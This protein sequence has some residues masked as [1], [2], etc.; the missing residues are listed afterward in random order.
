MNEKSKEDTEYDKVK[1]KNEDGLNVSYD[2]NELDQF[3]PHLM[4]EIINKEK[5]IQI[6]SID[7]DVEESKQLEEKNVTCLDNLSN[8]KAIDFIRRCSSNEEAIEILDYLLERDEIT[9]EE[10]RELKNQIDNGLEKFIKKSGGFKEP[11]YYIRKY[12]HNQET[13]KKRDSQ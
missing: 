8:P 5:S 7:Y 2:K 1:I 6:D 10:Y 11:G 9:R 4:D 13:N 12:Y 3:L